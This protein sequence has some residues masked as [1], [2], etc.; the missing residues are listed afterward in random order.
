MMVQTDVPRCWYTTPRKTSG[1]QW[2]SSPRAGQVTPWAL[3]PRR[4]LNT[5][6]N[7]KDTS[8][9]IWFKFVLNSK[10]H[11][12]QNVF[13]SLWSSCYSVV[14]R[15]MT[16]QS[17]V[18]IILVTSDLLLAADSSFILFIWPNVVVCLFVCRVQV[19][20][21][22]LTVRSACYD[23]V[24][25]S[26]VMDPLRGGGGQ[27]QDS[28]G[29]WPDW[30][31]GRSI[32]CVAGRRL[33]KHWADVL[34]CCQVMRWRVVSRLVLCR[35]IPRPP[36]SLHHPVP[37]ILPSS[38]IHPPS[39]DTPVGDDPSWGEDTAATGL[40]T[41]HSPCLA[42]ITRTCV[43]YKRTILRLANIFRVLHI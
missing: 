7:T 9:I 24:V 35:D 38:T 11:C 10:H 33:S 15:R 37:S 4:L 12:K 1:R 18:E 41:S 2:V 14:C 27:G 34:I 28:G 31:Q 40:T 23:G 8:F 22:W 36:P 32:V 25:M 42:N 5:V 29:V 19:E 39:A 16:H 6:S 21:S 17:S 26:D 20:K 30:S 13:S 3:C 43:L